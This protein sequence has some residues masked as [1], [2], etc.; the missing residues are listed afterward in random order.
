MFSPSPPPSSV[1]DGVPI[2]VTITAYADK[3]YDYVR[4]NERARE[5][6]RA[7][8]PCDR[9]RHGTHTPLSFTTQTMKTPPT[10]YLLKQAAS[11]AKGAAKPG[12]GTVGSVS[13]D[14]VLAVAR[15]KATDV[16]HVPLASVARSGAATARSMGLKVVEEGGK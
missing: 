4:W 1:Q 9:E 7:G 14:D 11:L 5:R 16:P 2:P 10:S 6:A 12:H 15:V 13:A 3:S 8:L